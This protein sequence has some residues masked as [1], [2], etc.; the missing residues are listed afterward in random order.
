MV[1]VY[2]QQLQFN[3]ADK[4]RVPMEHG[5]LGTLAFG[6]HHLNFLWG[7]ESPVKKY[8]FFLY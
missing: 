5:L 3:I 1:S 4:D 2:M 7:L 8:I 6:I